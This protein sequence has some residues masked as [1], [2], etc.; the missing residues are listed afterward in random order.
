MN[1]T[2][3]MATAIVETKVLSDDQIEQLIQ[4]A[5]A[6][7]HARAGAIA[8]PAPDHELT[9]QIDTSEFAQRKAIPR[10]EHGL[11]RQ[12]YIQEQ[13]GVA[14]VKPELLAT[15]EQ[16][17]LAEQLRTVEAQ[18]KKKKSKKQVSNSYFSDSLL[19]HEENHPNF[20]LMQISKSL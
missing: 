3:D 6:R 4:E 18:K 14:Q 19:L 13:Q 11:E 5:E 17:T 12:S 1:D 2:S 15:K 7:A 9:L 20:L 10:L 8:A 16:H